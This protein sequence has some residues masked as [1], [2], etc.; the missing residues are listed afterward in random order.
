MT[1]LRLLLLLPRLPH[2]LQQFRRRYQHLRLRLRL[3]LLPLHLPHLL[4]HPHPHLH[5]FR[6]LHL[7]HQPLAPVQMLLLEHKS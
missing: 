6:L 4:L 3:R 7:V 5:P 2:L 1:L